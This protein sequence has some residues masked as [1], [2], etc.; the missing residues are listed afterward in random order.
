M[1]NSTTNYANSRPTKDRRSSP[2][3]RGKNK[4]QQENNGI[5]NIAVDE[6]LLNETQTVS[7][8]NHEAPEFL[9]YDYDVND[10]YQVDNMSLE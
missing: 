9:E 7:A 1:G 2:V 5:V 8:T 6:I 4:R 3:P 10:L